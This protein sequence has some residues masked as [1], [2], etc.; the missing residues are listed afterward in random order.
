[1]SHGPVMNTY[2]PV[3]TSY[4][5]PTSDEGDGSDV[6]YDSESSG[7]PPKHEYRSAYDS[8]SGYSSPS[9]SEGD[10][11]EVVHKQYQ[12]S[13]YPDQNDQS[14]MK[15]DPDGASPD[16]SG[17][18]PAPSGTAHKAEKPT[19]DDQAPLQGPSLP[20]LAE[21]FDTSTL[22]DDDKKFLS[23]LSNAAGLVMAKGE[24]PADQMQAVV[25]AARDPKRAE[26]VSNAALKHKDKLETLGQDATPFVGQVLESLLQT[27]NSKDDKRR[28]PDLEKEWLMVIGTKY[29]GPLADDTLASS[30]GSSG[31]SGSKDS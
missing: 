30:S 7:P 21:K 16:P 19:A 28:A 2:N 3:N 5:D 27:A 13:V 29:D 20:K 1:M 24:D 4:G 22:T 12:R 9:D 8:D 6:P 11:D 31:S 23:S 10:N 15:A 18:N 26:A 14:F 17:P 25:D